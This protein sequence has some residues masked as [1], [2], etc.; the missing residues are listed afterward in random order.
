M[1]CLSEAGN[2]SDTKNGLKI[3]K[4]EM[5]VREKTKPASELVTQKPETFFQKKKK[6]TGSELLGQECDSSNREVEWG[7]YFGSPDGCMSSFLGPGYW[8]L[9]WVTRE[10]TGPM[11]D[12]MT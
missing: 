5:G 2:I 11:R 6:N 4:G 12:S 10:E 8:M 3:T 9:L 1:C 7:L